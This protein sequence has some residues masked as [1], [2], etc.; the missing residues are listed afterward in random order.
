MWWHGVAGALAHRNFRLLWFAALGSTIGT[1]MQQFAESWLVKTLTEPNS[2]FYLSLDV[3]FGQLPI[4]FFCL[5]GGVIADR[6]D[7]R[8][9]LTG[10]QLVQAFSAFSLASLVFW[11]H[12]QVWHILALSF[13]SGCGQAF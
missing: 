2:A 7:R 12:I 11:G 9:L 8:R 10:S 13:I 1:W 6:H 5:I 4:I 3:L